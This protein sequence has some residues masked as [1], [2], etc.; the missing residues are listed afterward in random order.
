M[1]KMKLEL[2]RNGIILQ[3]PEGKHLYQEGETDEESI[4][5]FADFLWTINTLYG[6]STSRYSEFRIKIDIISGDKFEDGQ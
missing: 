1:T 3:G 2:A 6:P 4:R 5:R